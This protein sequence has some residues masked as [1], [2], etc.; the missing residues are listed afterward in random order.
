MDYWKHGRTA[1]ELCLGCRLGLL[2]SGLR[3]LGFGRRSAISAW[4]Y[5]SGSEFGVGLT[6]DVSGIRFTV[7]VGFGSEKTRYT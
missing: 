5:G 2:G 3:G 1:H 6:S 4:V 7:L